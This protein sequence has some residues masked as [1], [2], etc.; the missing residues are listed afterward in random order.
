MFRKTAIVLMMLAAS[1]GARERSVGSGPHT[2]RASIAIVTGI[3]RSISPLGL[4]CP[5]ASVD[6]PMAAWVIAPA[7]GSADVQLQISTQTAISGEPHP[8]DRVE[9]MADLTALR[10]LQVTLL[11]SIVTGTVK[12][13]TPYG[14]ACALPPAVCPIAAWSIVSNGVEVG[15]QVTNE[16]RL[17][18]APRVGDTVDV[19]VQPGTPRRAL[20]VVRR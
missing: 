4:L 19:I 17:L 14:I 2:T 15:L 6:C 7:D 9:V 18:G 12:S 20:F 1:A 16:T 8:G 5:P 13:I 3:I 10:A 11:P